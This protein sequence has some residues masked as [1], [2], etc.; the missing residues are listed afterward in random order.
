MVQIDHEKTLPTGGRGL[1]RTR[2]ASIIKTAVRGLQ[3]SIIE[4]KQTNSK[5]NA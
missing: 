4:K 2:K 3:K 1:P 5:E